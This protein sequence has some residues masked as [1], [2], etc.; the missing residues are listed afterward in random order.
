MGEYFSKRNSL[1]SNVKVELDS[2]KYTAKT[3]L[4]IVTG[5]DTS[6]FAKKIDLVNLK[7]DVDKLDIDQLKNIPSALSSLKS[8]VDQLDIDKFK[9]LSSE[10]DQLDIDKLKYVPSG[11]SSLKSK[12]DKLDADKLIPAPVNLSKLSYIVKNDVAKKNVYHAM[13]R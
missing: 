10:V 2:S 3:D 4:K 12:V 8:K 6:S 9:N 1:G 11:L 5:V 7:S 13:L